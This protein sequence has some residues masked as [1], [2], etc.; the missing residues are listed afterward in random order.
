MDDLSWRELLEKEA[1]LTA[2]VSELSFE[3]STISAELL[4]VK[5]SAM[6][7]LY[8]HSKTKRYK[9]QQGVCSYC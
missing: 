3:L 6:R 1:E 7:V 4:K 9:T 2:R 8:L 5:K